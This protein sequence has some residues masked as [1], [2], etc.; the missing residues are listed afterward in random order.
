MA[1]GLTAALLGTGLCCTGGVLS[2]QH[3]V[4]LK[5]HCGL[6]G[7]DIYGAGLIPEFTHVE[8][9]RV[10]ANESELQQA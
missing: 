8:P 3:Q 9:L 10:C 6:G 1:L 5:V 7:S 4:G 2:P